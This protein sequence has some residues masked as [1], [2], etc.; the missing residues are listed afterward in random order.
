M[1]CIVK[2]NLKNK[3]V[4]IDVNH[5]NSGKNYKKQVE[6]VNEVIDIKLCNTIY[7]N[8]IKGVMIESFIEEG[9]QKS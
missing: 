2:E 9:C 6:I 3:S 8:F 5:A 1:I 7:K 4:I